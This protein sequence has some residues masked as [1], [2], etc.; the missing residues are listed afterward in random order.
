MK[1]LAER[2]GKDKVTCYLTYK[3]R[4]ATVP[5]VFY[6][7]YG[8]KVI[9][10]VGIAY[11][12]TIVAVYSGRLAPDT[13]LLLV[14]DALKMGRVIIMGSTYST[15]TADPE[16]REIFDRIFILNEAPETYDDILEL[17]EELRR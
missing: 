10:V 4:N 5:Y 13:A 12:G 9:P 14:R 11:N 15:S 17:A 2:F 6:E 8:F 7:A 1:A 16:D 3:G